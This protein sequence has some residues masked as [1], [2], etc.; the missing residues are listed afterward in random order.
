MKKKYLRLSLVYLLLLTVFY[1][2]PA[3][4]LPWDHLGIFDLFVHFAAYGLFAWLALSVL[5]SCPLRWR[6]LAP[7][8]FV[9]AVAHFFW[10][11]YLQ[12]S[13]AGLDRYLSYFDLVAGSA[14][15]IAGILLHIR[16]AYRNCNCSLMAMASR[17]TPPL[18]MES[19][20]DN[21]SGPGS[22]PADSIGNIPGLNNIIAESFGWKALQLRPMA[23]ISIDMV[24]TGKSLVSLPHFSYGNVQN[25][26]GKAISAR[27]WQT[28]LAGFALPRN[29]AQM[30]IRLAWQDPHLESAKVASWLKLSDSMDKQMQAFSAN[31]RRKIR[32]GQ[33]HGFTVEQGGIGLLHEFWKVYA[34]HL[35]HLGSVALPRRFFENLLNKCGPGCGH[36]FILRHQGRVV[37]AAFN[38]THEGFYENGW[39]ATLHHV[40]GLYASYVMHHAMI[41]HAIA[42]GCHTY[43]FGRST[44]GGGVHRFK[45]QW[46]AD[47]V[48]LLW[49]HF[50]AQ[51]INLRSH[52]WL[53]KLWKFLPWLLRQRLGSYLA[54]WVY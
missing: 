34:R 38:L 16:R 6:N 7:W 31:L 4:W 22:G 49:S 41:G 15:A 42:L 23:G 3:R 54:K 17:A 24:C 27:N 44:T 8:I 47:D 40:Q 51:R 37:G 19:L 13:L 26:T 25:T 20:E 45:I 43:S 32:R 5:G 50:P 14:G 9:M 21:D 28:I 46:G 30:E 18:G 29:I 1:F 52:T 2:L 53:H 33:H 39:F 48:P 35:D 36:I 11:G 12:R 10:M